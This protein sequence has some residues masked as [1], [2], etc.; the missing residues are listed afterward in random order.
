VSFL[1]VMLFSFTD[2][3]E[4]F[5]VKFYDIRFLI[6]RPVGEWDRLTF[7]DIDDNSVT[8][9]GQYPW[10]RNL[11]ARGLESLDRVGAS[12]TTMDIM[13]LDETPLQLNREDFRKI[14]AKADAGRRLNRK[15]LDSAA[16]DMD[17]M[18]SG[19][20]K[21]SGRV[22][23]AYSF[24][25]DPLVADVVERQKKQDFLEAEK[26]FN[27]LATIKVPADKIE[28][29]KSLGEEKIKALAYP[30][31]GLMASGKNF[32]FVNRDTDIDGA[33][34]RVRL[35]R[36]F[37]GRLYFNLALMMVAD[38]CGVP[39]ERIEVVPGKSITLKNAVNPRTHASGDIS[40]PIDSRGMM[41]VNWA[42]HNKREE[43]FKV[44]PFF[45]L[46]DYSAYADA[47]HDY[48][49]SAQQRRGNSELDNL[50]AELESARAEYRAEKKGPERAKIWAGISAL[51]KKIR[52]VKNEYKKDLEGEVGR[53]KAAAKNAGPEGRKDLELAQDDLKAVD[54]VSRVEDLSDNLV[55]T[56][57]TTTGGTDIG[58][59][60]LTKDYALVGTYHNTV[61]TIL[62]GAYIK[63]AG[64]LL[65]YLIMLGIALLMGFFVQLLDARKSLLVM[66]SSFAGINIIVM[67]V[68][69]LFDIWIDQLGTMLSILLPSLTIAGIKFIGEERQKRFIKNAFSHYLSPGVIEQIIVNPESLQLGGEMR[70]ITIFFS[71]VA[72][73]STISEK[74]NPKELVALLN[75]YL[76]E[77][78]DI[79]LSYGGTVD[80]YEGDAIMAFYG[81]PYAD[82]RHPLNACMAAIDMKKRL[83]EMQEQWKKI[84]RDALFA[85]MG[86]NTGEAVVG[87]MGSRTRMNYTA[88]GDS[89]NLASRL[90]GANKF[91]DT[92][93]MISETTYEGAR[94]EIEGR[95][96]GV[97]RVVGK[98]E[99]VSIYELLGK[100]GTLPDRM[101]GMLEKYNQALEL[102]YKRE[103][104]RARALFKEG[105]KIVP[106]DGPS[107]KYLGLCE[108]YSKNPRSWDG[109][110]TLKSK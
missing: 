32:G 60:P 51:K 15:D 90:E 42:K 82:I 108:E 1:V 101:Y 9:L 21:Q 2:A 8:T 110:F 106:D 38:A 19:S 4:R 40:I 79:I 102:F 29:Y 66:V 10:P 31:P 96:L 3:Y 62:H 35:V 83:R 30:I 11:Y 72:K 100:K 49:K 22:L 64:P 13:F 98:S 84:G 103:W 76:S 80:K 37:N 78:T 20:V 97:I 107:I 28:D 52:T 48:F 41:Y 88:M 69:A 85:R 74:L 68:F 45:A 44:I 65:N 89:V 5:E 46:L 18:F 63:K 54:L 12:Q 105:L 24:S 7:V 104:K 73:F 67:G 27:R 23:L 58:I 14:T 92:H 75:E 70:N 61:N 81:A 17:R 43:S 93:A 94:D 39:L 36:L 95:K 56:G 55:V 26:R 87:N 59:I 109:I 77:M 91:F 33:I 53:L 86:M 71:D 6:K 34:R 47:V 57:L 99:A 16:I 25:E 50:N